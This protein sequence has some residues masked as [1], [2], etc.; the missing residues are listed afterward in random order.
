MKTEPMSSAH[1]VL[2]M[3]IGFL[4]LLLSLKVMVVF[5]VG[6]N[7]GWDNT[8]FGKPPLVPLAHRVLVPK[9]IASVKATIPD[10]VKHYT[11]PFLIALRDSS[12]GKDV[13]R[14]RYDLSSLP[15][16]LADKN[17][18]DL[19][20]KMAI[21]YIT[22][23]AFLA[24]LYILAHALFPDSIAIAAIAPLLA[25]VVITTFS[26][27]FAYTY[28]FAELFFSCACFYFLFKKR[29]C[30][31]FFCLALATL[32][33]ETSIFVIIFYWICF[34]RQLPLKQYL[35]VGLLQSGIYGAIKIGLVI[36]FHTR[37]AMYASGTYE[38]TLLDNLK[39][40]HRYGHPEF[41]WLTIITILLFYR[42]SEKPPF[43]KDGLWMV[44]ANLGAYLLTCNP[45]EYRDLYW[46]MPVLIIMASHSVINAP[47][48]I[49]GP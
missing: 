31:Y 44:G 14:E 1:K 15:L 46:G 16:P 6:S 45:G 2:S 21:V 47:R 27:K 32:T 40:M 41:A 30:S 38:N 11:T 4:Y 20:L 24:M 35:V 26:R 28:D 22:L 49:A 3:G 37:E 7:L 13:L 25:I 36:Y 19:F 43:L 48:F 8:P 42:W 23:L 10:G 39:F 29:W 18:F 34:F 12:A 9:V 33:K 5:L 17:I